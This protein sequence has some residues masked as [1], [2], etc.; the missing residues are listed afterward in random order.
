[1]KD[2]KF[3]KEVITIL[4]I[5]AIIN[6]FCFFVCSITGHCANEVSSVLPYLCQSVNSFYDE[7]MV[8]TV[9]EEINNKY[10][11]DDIYSK[12]IIISLGA[13]YNW[14]T[15]NDYIQVPTYMV[16]VIPNGDNIATSWSN[17]ANF[18]N[19]V[20]E[21][22]NYWVELNI[23]P[24]TS[25]RVQ[26]NNIGNFHYVVTKSSSSGVTSMRLFGAYSPVTISNSFYDIQVPNYNYPIYVNGA[27]TTSDPQLVTG[28]V[29][30]YTTGQIDVG[31][32]LDLPSL[33]SLL[34][35]ISNIWNGS[36]D[37]NLPSSDSNLSVSENLRNFLSTMQS[38]LSGS[39]NNL[40]SKIKSY[41]DNLQQKLT[42]LG[43]SIS[44]NIWNGFNTLMQNIKDYFGPKLDYIIEKFNY[45]TSEP[46]PEYIQD[47]IESTSAYT[48]I[49]SIQTSAISFVTSFTGVS[50][51]DDYVLTLH[52]ED[53]SL[54]GQSDPFYL[55]LNILNPV[56]T[57]IRGF[58]WVVVS[59]GIF[60]SIID[61]LPN[62]IN[63]GG[64][65][66]D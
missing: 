59:Y 33:D 7:D 1:M 26:P 28:Y 63:G 61:S 24:F 48:D 40:G 49:S 29:L 47:F 37:V 11:D 18:E 2:K 14:F 17:G 45:I 52:I 22:S 44:T 15:Y 46:D 31:E 66:D 32:F 23:I 34:N 55:H 9:L 65:E 51:P 42:D 38:N 64:G 4:I 39:I 16:Y 10:P 30:S 3:L 35:N 27:I 60:I 20:F 53:I 25:Y 19:F 12:R 57:Y 21:N 36:T 5:G 8:N 54:L 58:L 6:G 43:N 62:Y 50:E 41:F 56:K 13:E